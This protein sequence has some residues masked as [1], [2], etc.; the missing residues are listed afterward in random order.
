[1]S[2]LHL[3][4]S[5]PLSSLLYPYDIHQVTVELFDEE[6]GLCIPHT[7]PSSSARIITHLYG[8]ELRGNSKKDKKK[9]EDNPLACFDDESS[10]DA[11]AGLDTLRR[12]MAE[13]S[14]MLVARYAREAL[15]WMVSHWS[16]QHPPTPATLGIASWRP[17]IH[18][19]R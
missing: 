9:E 18:V 6:R 17:F 11:P 10:T 1:M 5:S 16:P 12:L 15:V 8:E 3:S 4:P 19:G 14:E 7:I 2:C 13:T